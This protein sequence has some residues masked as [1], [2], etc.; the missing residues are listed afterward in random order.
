M[1]ED[2]ILEEEK[3][4]QD[5]S[6]KEWGSKKKLIDEFFLQAS[7]EPIEPPEPIPETPTRSFVFETL[8]ED[9]KTQE[10]E[11]TQESEE[12][13]KQETQQSA[14]EEAES[15][16]AEPKKIAEEVPAKNPVGIEKKSYWKKPQFWLLV[17]AI[18]LI[19][20][21]VAIFF[22]NRTIPPKIAF[23]DSETNDLMYGKVLYN[24]AEIGE[25][26]GDY[27]SGLPLDFCSNASQLALKQGD[28]VY[29]AD[30]Y[31]GDCSSKK[32]TYVIKRK[33]VGITEVVLDFYAED[34][35]QKL[36]G[37]LFIDGQS[38][39]TISGSRKI[40]VDD[41]RAAKTIRLV[42]GEKDISWANDESKC[43]GA[44]KIDFTVPS[45]G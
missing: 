20:S 34:T 38:H 7:K 15:D 42:S 25:F 43:S 9:E 21:I 35:G 44:G 5:S 6:D 23:V 8:E 39:G 26:S 10:D 30:A 24:G 27:F 11:E 1:V 31:P 41:C 33:E 18:V 16:D 40:S 29:I 17:I 12:E 13:E 22:Y 14:D 28:E 4:A 32:I 2:D 19:L 45:L 3:P 36:A 37:N